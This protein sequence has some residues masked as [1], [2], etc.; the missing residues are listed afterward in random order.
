MITDTSTPDLT[1]LADAP[2]TAPAPQWHVSPIVDTLAYHL[3]WAWILIPLAFV[4]DDQHVDYRLVFAL[5][6]GVNFAHRHFGLPYAYLDRQVFTE[7]RRRLVRVPLVLLGLLAATPLFL[8]KQVGGDFGRTFV[9]TA[10]FVAVLWNFWHTPMQKFG[11]LRLYLAKSGLPPERRTPP[12][13]DRLLVLCWFPLLFT[14]IGPTYKA[15]IFKYGGSVA[16]YTRPLIAFME[17][18]S[19]LLLTPSVLLVV[20]A[21]AAFLIYEWRANRLRS[22]P[23][24]SMGLGTTLGFS[25]L[26]WAHPVK[27]YVALAFSHAV[28]YMV[29]VWAFQRRRYSGPDA[30]PGVM[31]TLLGRPIAFYLVLGVGLSAVAM[32]EF[33]WARKVVPGVEPLR[34]GGLSVRQWFFYYAAY[35]SMIHFYTDGFL[36]KMRSRAVQRAI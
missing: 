10:V 12:W 18:H 19:W 6:L 28:E 32:G 30:A 34:F 4:G 27:A 36:W 26:L 35:E 3:S 8:D 24:L 5:V 15:L 22:W 20:G 29:F 17:R 21:I 25:A 31:R 9:N 2:A 23:R 33:F 1:Q 16:P 7:H 14:Y 11:I 13:V